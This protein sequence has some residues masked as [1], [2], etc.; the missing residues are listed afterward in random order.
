MGKRKPLTDT[1]GEVRELTVEDAAKGKPFPSLPQAEQEILLS[2]R[3]RGGPKAPIL[4][5]HK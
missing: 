5:D 4:A 2:L 1:E 3:R